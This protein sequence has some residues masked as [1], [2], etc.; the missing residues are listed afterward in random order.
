MN[1]C[2]E[3]SLCNSLGSQPEQSQKHPKSR[4]PRGGRPLASLCLSAN[5]REVDSAPR[6]G[7]QLDS[8]SL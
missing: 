2:Q 4:G 5:T 7:H 8:V 6:L 1:E 3:G